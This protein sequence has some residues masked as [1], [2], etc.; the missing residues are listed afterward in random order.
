MQNAYTNT[1]LSYHIFGLLS[2]NSFKVE[3]SLKNM[4]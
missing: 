1:Y 4:A 2:R 3:K